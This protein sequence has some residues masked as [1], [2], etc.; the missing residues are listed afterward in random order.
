[1]GEIKLGTKAHMK[2]EGIYRM[3]TEEGLVTTYL[4]SQCTKIISKASL[5]TVRHC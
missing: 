1:M 5:K 2:Q 3:F 4:L